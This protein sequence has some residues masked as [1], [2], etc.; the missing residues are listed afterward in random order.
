MARRRRGATPGVPRTVRMRCPMG[1]PGRRPAAGD[2]LSGRAPRSHRGG[3]WFDP[4]IAH[5]CK[6][7]S[8]ALRTALILRVGWGLS[9]VS[10]GIWEIAF[11]PLACPVIPVDRETGRPGT[12]PGPDRRGCED[13]D[14]PV[15][16]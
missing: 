12:H 6:S 10:G 16:A 8:E 15:I 14:E 4:S 2:W 9:P 7:R 13:P 1:A 3:H 11:S 5:R